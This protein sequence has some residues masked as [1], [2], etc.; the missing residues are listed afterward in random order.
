MRVYNN[1]DEFENVDCPV[2]TTGTFDGVHLGHK[3]ILSR[4]LE[5]AKKNNGE[6]VLLTFHPHPRLI[7]F[8]NDSRL[9]L[10][11]T[12][13][14][15]IRQLEDAGVDHLIIHPFTKEFSRL[16]SVEFV[17]DILVNKIGTKK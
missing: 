10:L 8:P 6:S 5:I 13:K 9:Q 14:E 12:Q 2:L 1:I 15:K 4:L 3:K 16:S 11:S 7:L 17:R